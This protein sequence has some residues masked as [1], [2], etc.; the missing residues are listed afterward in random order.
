MMHNQSEGIDYSLMMITVME[1]SEIEPAAFTQEKK[2]EPTLV[3]GWLKMTGGIAVCNSGSSNHISEPSLHLD[4]HAT[5]V[6]S[7]NRLSV[8]A[9]DHD[10][11]R[12]SFFVDRRSS[13][14]RR[15]ASVN[16]S[17]RHDKD[18]SAHV[19]PYCSFGRN[20]RD[21][22]REKDNDFR[23]KLINLEKGT[24]DFL[25]SFI[26]TRS[27]T[28]TLRRSQ[29]MISRR[30]G[31]VSSKRTGND[32][33]NAPSS[34]SHV[35]GIGKASFEKDF[36]SLGA[37]DKQRPPEISRVCSP[38]P[39]SA[40]QNL[41]LCTS[42]IIGVNGWTSSLAE[43][44]VIIGGNGPLLS[45][46]QQTAPASTTNGP[47][48][49]TGLNMAETLA[50]APLRTRDAPKLSVDTQR[51]EE[52][53]IKKSRQLIPVTP[54]VPKA[55]VP[56]SSEKLRPKGP[57]GGDA[58]AKFGQQSSV[59][60]FNQTSQGSSRSDIC[61]SSQVGNFQVLNRE[62]NGISPT[63]RDAPGQTNASRV[64]NPLGGV[65][66]ATAS[67]L[68]SPN[69]L[70][71][72]GKATNFPATTSIEKRPVSQQNRSDFFNSLRKKASASHSSATADFN[73]NPSSILEKSD[74]QI[75][76]TSASVDT[77]PKCTSVSDSGLDCSMGHGTRTTGTLDAHDSFPPSN[78]EM[79][80]SLDPAEE[81]RL[82][83][84]FGWQEDPGEEEEALTAEEIEAFIKE[85]EKLR[86]SSKF[87]RRNLRLVETLLS[88]AGAG[89]PG[90]S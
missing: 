57:R 59:Q 66:L 86:P 56:N 47:S 9:C 8:N 49:T 64:L 17:R 3:P 35:S 58:S 16:G 53:A 28:D 67:P 44:P 14:Y 33:I 51:L 87:C 72:N 52:L 6:S 26:S 13:S 36:P 20:H 55:L 81:E 22:D 45:S 10:R 76:G 83:R 85:Y 42:G 75:I 4:D 69:N 15:S 60:H 37:E 5:G 2:N 39:S 90:F 89:A 63:A 31:N 61:K 73:S 78:G 7:R 84:L 23:Q 88:E 41:P 74:E 25:D 34:G 24:R 1:T 46:V 30:R 48:T 62:R 65:P 18:N 32:T 68:R 70:K 21:R 38:G 43:V 79:S 27:E 40:V 82:L 11:P 71:P 19:Q 29:S 80:S 77:L 50:Q 54:S 12:S